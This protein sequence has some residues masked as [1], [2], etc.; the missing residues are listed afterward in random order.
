MSTA[1]YFN[2]SLSD[3]DR[4]T[5]MFGGDLFLYSTCTSSLALVD[6][7]CELINEAFSP[8]S[9][10]RQAHKCFD[11]DEFVARASP[12]KSRFTNDPR[13]KEICQHLISNMG[14][15]PNRTYFDLPRLRVVPPRDYLSTGISYNYKPHRDTWYAH[16]RQLINYWVP[17]Y[18]VGPATVMSMY[19]DYFDRAVDNSSDGWNY[20]EWV[21]NARYSAAVNIGVENRLHPLPAEDVSTSTDLRIVPNVGDM[22]VFSTCQLHASV[23]NVTDSVRYSFD[24]RTLNID[25]VLENRGAPN[26]DA[27]ASG[28]TLNDFLRASDLAPLDTEVDPR[29]A[30]NIR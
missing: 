29:L 7:A 16:P 28:S 27:H 13:T 12:L 19:T 22:L 30:S 18:E 3:D 25:D 9:D 23:P 10:P 4:R 14:G 21:A 26:V 17:I 11:V 15:D 20:D 8:A 24:V 1:I 2:R 5:L 6:W